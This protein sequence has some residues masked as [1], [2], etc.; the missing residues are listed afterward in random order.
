MGFTVDAG[1]AV[2][3]AMRRAAGLALTL[4]CIAVHAFAL[5]QDAAD[6]LDG[7]A[8]QIPPQ[9]RSHIEKD[10]ERFDFFGELREEQCQDDLDCDHSTG[11]V[12][13]RK[14]NDAAGHCRCPPD[15]PIKDAQGQCQ[16]SAEQ[17]PGC[18]QS[19]DCG[20]PLFECVDRQ[21]RCMP[22]NVLQTDASCGPPQ[23]GDVRPDQPASK[24]TW[25]SPL[26]FLFSILL[27]MTC[28]VFATRY[29]KDEDALDE[30]MSEA[31][32]A[33]AGVASWS[34]AKAAASSSSAARVQPSVSP[35][36]PNQPGSL[37][38]RSP[39]PD[40]G[41][42]QGASSTG[43]PHEGEESDVRSTS[44]SSVHESEGG[45]ALSLEQCALQERGRVVPGSEA[46][47]STE[48]RTGDAV[49]TSCES[50]NVE[51]RPSSMPRPIKQ[52]SRCS[53][54][55][56]QLPEFVRSPTQQGGDV[57]WPDMVPVQRIRRGLQLLG[58]SPRRD[59][60]QHFLDGRDLF[61]REEEGVEVD[62][63]QLLQLPR[64]EAVCKTVQTDITLAPAIVP[65]AALD[66]ALW[67]LSPS[68]CDTWPL[69]R[70]G[71]AASKAVPLL[72]VDCGD[73]R[74]G[75]SAGLEPG[76]S[77][78]FLPERHQKP[79]APVDAPIVHQSPNKGIS[80]GAGAASIQETKGLA[81]A[82]S[83]TVR[84]RASGEGPSTSSQQP[85]SEI[86][87]SEGRQSSAGQSSP[88][89]AGRN[90][91]RYSIRQTSSNELDRCGSEADAEN[92]TS[93]P[94][95]SVAGRGLIQAIEEASASVDPTSE[96]PSELMGMLPRSYH[97]SS[98][99]EGSSQ[100]GWVRRLKPNPADED[101]SVSFQSF[102]VEAQVA[103][104]EQQNGG[105]R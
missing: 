57:G 18:Q 39:E 69:S 99:G 51:R 37:Q 59:Q 91:S 90:K 16:P 77:E 58:S 30:E 60:L 6:P 26:A 43:Q 42:E 80:G 88:A 70:C 25:L 21:C 17:Q 35:S 101:T 49:P 3:T 94:A 8:V 85:H 27:L 22:P 83:V 86:S 54:E 1:A 11:R 98:V 93:A 47:M 12:C 74:T 19:L 84:V 102:D 46:I 38:P 64:E 14:P 62:P 52:I 67:P 66:S 9:A 40:S 4:A 36:A 44:A 10:P 32:A 75:R 15:K 7:T 28:T 55:G 63:Q 104:A 31:G 92:M 5:Q 2:P 73:Y 100:G 33:G 105:S 79:L 24:S 20:K 61:E 87:R 76:S 34:A 65:F 41:S 13:V 53:S 81:I 96:P 103:A 45:K 82:C 78:L 71:T 56:I 95:N 68:R 50:A 97:E 29:R 48:G 23:G 72:T 89:C